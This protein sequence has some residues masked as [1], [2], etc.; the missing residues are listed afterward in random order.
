RGGRD[1]QFFQTAQQLKYAA[2]TG[3]QLQL[4][5]LTFQG[6]R[7]PAELIWIPPNER[8]TFQA[9][10][11]VGAGEKRPRLAFTGVSKAEV[12]TLKPLDAMAVAADAP[13]RPVPDKP[14]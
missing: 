1:G 13:A 3:E 12:L 9:V 2:E 7:R 8:R 4:S 14:A 11:E 5:P 6:T 10:F